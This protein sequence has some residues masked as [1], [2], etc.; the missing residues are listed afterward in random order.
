MLDKKTTRRD[1]LTLTANSLAGVGL[2][3]VGWIF[4]DSMNPA[5][6]V[7]ALS[8]IE[9]D[10]SGVKQGHTMV[11]KW[12]GKPVFIRNRKPEEI[13]VARNAIVDALP[14]PE[15]D[16]QR[17]KEGNEKF[18]V[19]VGVCTHLGCIP[20]ANPSGWFCPCHGSHYDISGRVTKGPAPKN[21]EVP[22]YKFIGKNKI[23]IG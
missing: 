10:I 3:S 11:V 19:V 13:L 15:Q 17:T 2:A 7:L 22:E 6:D 18:L 4:I 12:R 16:S 1:F 20:N 9:V 23:I 5:K 8:S 14:D 21:L